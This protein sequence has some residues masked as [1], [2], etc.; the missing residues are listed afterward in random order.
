M[1]DT[2][3]KKITILKSEL[4]SISGQNFTYNVK[5]RVVSEDKNRYSHWS[6]IYNLDAS[7][8]VSGTPL[9][10]TFTYSYLVETATGPSSSIVKSARINWVIPTTNANFLNFDIFVKRYT[11]SSWGS[12]DFI[13]TTSTNTYVIPQVGSETQIMVLVQTPLFPKIVHTSAKIFETE[14]I[15]Y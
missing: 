14:A 5:Y 2:G 11:G 10:P 9:I 13:G 7:Q 6:N 15:T 3:I 12:Y 1:S 4:P 8:D